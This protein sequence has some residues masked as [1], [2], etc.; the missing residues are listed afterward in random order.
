MFRTQL[1]RRGR[2]GPGRA[3]D[4]PRAGRHPRVAATRCDDRGRRHRPGGPHRHG[5][6]LHARPADRHPPD[7][8][9]ALGFRRARDHRD[10]RRQRGTRPGCHAPARRG[11]RA[12]VRRRPDDGSRHLER[13]HPAPG[14]ASR[15]DHQRQHG[16]PGNEGELRRRR[17]RRAAARHGPLGGRRPVHFCARPRRALQQH[18]AGRRGPAVHPTRTQGGRPRHVPRQPARQR[19]GGE[20]LHP[21]PLGRVC[22]RPG[23]TQHGEAAEPAD[24]RRDPHG[25]RQQLGV[26]TNRPRPHLRRP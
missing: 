19:A 10:P 13:G 20:V 21:R 18:D 23:G 3:R 12:G 8:D 6:P 11:F 26:G 4:G 16:Q 9:R 17:G 2:A 25:G 15:H 5:R 1:G 14:T 24:I 22:R 7:Q